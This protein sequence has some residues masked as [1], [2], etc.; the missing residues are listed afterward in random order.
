MFNI[1]KQLEANRVE[2]VA[3]KRS[4]MK[5]VV[6]IYRRWVSKRAYNA[7][8]L[9]KREEKAVAAKTNAELADELDARSEVLLTESVMCKRTNKVESDRLMEEAVELATKAGE[10]RFL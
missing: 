8:V 10:L 5:V 1:I 7:L 4:L 9:T 3:P 6:S 2:V